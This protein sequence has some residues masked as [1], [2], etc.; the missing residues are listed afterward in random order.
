MARL[1]LHSV[2][3]GSS[4]DRYEDETKTA[5]ERPGNCLDRNER[6]RLRAR[7]VLRESHGIRARRESAHPC[8]SDHGLGASLPSRVMTIG[9]ARS[10]HIETTRVPVTDQSGRHTF[11]IE[12]TPVTR[13]STGDGFHEFRH[14]ASLQTFG[15]IDV[16]R[17]TETQFE[18]IDGQSFLL[19]HAQPA[20]SSVAK[21]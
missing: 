7:D 6:W 13:D 2:A 18:S 12:T 5:S 11:L 17:I 1:R 10:E 8:R 21:F 15:S 9:M 16:N 3:T 20:H 14:S 19:G 4:S